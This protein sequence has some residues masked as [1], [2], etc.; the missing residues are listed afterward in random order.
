LQWNYIAEIAKAELYRA[1]RLGFSAPGTNAWHD[2]LPALVRL[3]GTE[4]YFGE[5]TVTE[6]D[7]SE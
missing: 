4:N 1:A 6:E 3:G 5:F 2:P 7:T